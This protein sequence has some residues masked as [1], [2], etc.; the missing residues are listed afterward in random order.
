MKVE[1]KRGLWG[2]RKAEGLVVMIDVFRASN[3]ILAMLNSGVKE[4]IIVEKINDARS[5]K[6]RKPAYLLCGERKRIKPKDFD[7]GNSPA[8]FRRENRG[9]IFSSSACTRGIANSSQ[10]EGN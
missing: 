5:L 4:I 3:T 9:I 8:E 7:C 10:E 1:I 2:A 6:K